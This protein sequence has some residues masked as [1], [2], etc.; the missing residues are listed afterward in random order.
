MNTAATDPML[1]VLHR[2]RERFL[3]EGPPSLQHRRE[4]LDRL[5]T[6]LLEHQADIVAAVSSDFGH[7][8]PQE[9]LITE[10]YLLVDGIAGIARELP[11]WMKPER[12]STPIHL[13]P[14]KSWVEHQP[15]GVVGIMSPWNYPMNLAL[16]PLAAALAAGNRVMVKPSELTPATTALMAGMIGEAFTPEEVAVV[17]GG[18]E[19]GQ[20]F[21]RLPFDHLLFTG[22]TNV[23][24]QVMR[25]ASE[26]LVPVTL[27]LGGKSPALV[28]MGYPLEHAAA[29]I[30]FGTLFNAGQTCVAPDYALVPAGQQD[31]FVE[32][33]AAAVARLY[34]TLANNPDYTAIISE[35]HYGRLRGLVDDAA[36]KG[37]RVIEVNPAGERLDGLPTRKLALMV[38]L[39]PTD[40]MQVMQEEIFGP[41][42]PVVT[43]HTLDEAI[44]YINA[45]PRPLALYY[46]GNDSDRQRLV[47]TRTTS[48][49]VTINDTL[50]HFAQHAL[51]FGGV[52]ASGMGAYHGRDGFLTF[53]HRKAVFRQS[54][55]SGT[56][57]FRPPY[58]RTIQR[59]LK[60]LM[61]RAGA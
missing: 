4:L 28:D 26:H 19:V 53:S 29:S 42:L 7:R 54:R 58:G 48:G 40:E 43:Y 1:Q 22:S 34:P 37:G 13:F 17:T 57:M 39:D 6:S 32:L 3:A 61:W 33:L 5:K 20:A 56:G 9:T 21:S 55:W 12:R 52:G 45:R 2:Q 25:A 46:F 59:L 30:A 49:G 36:S 60:G 31:R 15:L 47:L 44:A 35:R 14:A 10:V 38:V 23:G 18:P 24:R 16:A 50:L 8:S 41:V 27:E 11:G 51:R